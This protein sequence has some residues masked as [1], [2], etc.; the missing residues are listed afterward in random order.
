MKRGGT[1][2]PRH[3]L[4]LHGRSENLHRRC[5]GLATI[6]SHCRSSSSYINRWQSS[7]L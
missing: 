6:Y 2:L 7:S 4:P 3:W 1:T 5:F